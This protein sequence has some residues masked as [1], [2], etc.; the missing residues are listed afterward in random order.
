MEDLLYTYD[1]F[2]FRV[3][4]MLRYSRDD[5]WVR[6]EGERAVVGVTD[7]LQQKAGDAA[8]VELVEVGTHLAAG[9]RLGT[10]ETIKA[11]VTLPC[12]LSGTVLAR[13]EA[14]EESPERVNQEPYGA[15]WLVELRPDDPAEVDRLLTAEAY[16]ELLPAKVA[17][18]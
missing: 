16:R 18:R 10:L 15:G 5:L 8:F 17:E 4:R 2:T 7:F 3:P 13:N 14:L 9:E 12:P 1:K 6:L 11:T